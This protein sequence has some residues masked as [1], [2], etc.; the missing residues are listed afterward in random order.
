MSDA[1]ATPATFP[2]AA[3][4]CGIGIRPIETHATEP[5][6]RSIP[7]QRRIR[8]LTSLREWD[9]CQEQ[10]SAPDKLLGA[11]DRLTAFTGNTQLSPSRVPAGGVRISIGVSSGSHGVSFE[12]RALFHVS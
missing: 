7:L 8:S 2:R 6:N 3:R 4:S 11:Q 5:S 12:K 10:T 9:G 1:G